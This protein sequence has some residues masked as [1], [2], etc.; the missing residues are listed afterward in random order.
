VSGIERLEVEMGARVMNWLRTI[1]GMAVLAMVWATAA[2]SSS[3]GQEAG[4]STSGTSAAA[5]TTAASVAAPSTIPGTP[6]PGVGPAV[7]H[8]QVGERASLGCPNDAVNPCDVDFTITS[9]ESGVQC[10]GDVYGVPLTPDEQ[11]VRFDIEITTAQ[12]FMNGPDVDTA[13]FTDNWGIGDERGVSQGIDQVISL[14]CRSD[15]IQKALYPGQHVKKS[16]V[17]KAP[18]TAT[19]LRLYMNSTGAGWTWDVPPAPG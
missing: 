7:L 2:C 17:V 9:I 13:F 5:T 18:K 12:Q 10:E 1:A 14:D 3:P 15:Q 16:I 19:T 8:K 11:K 4:S 6:A